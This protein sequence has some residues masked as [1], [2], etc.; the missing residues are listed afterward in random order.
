MGLD[1][2]TG[3]WDTLDMGNYRNRWNH[4]TAFSAAHNAV[5]AASTAA[6][7]GFPP[8]DLVARRVAQCPHSTPFKG[9]DALSTAVV[10][11]VPFGKRG[12]IEVRQ[13]VKHIGGRWDGR[14]KQ[15]TLSRAKC[16]P[17]AI[18]IINELRLYTGKTIAAPKAAFVSRIAIPALSRII[19]SVPYEDRQEVKTLGA[20]WSVTNR[21]WYLSVPQNPDQK[22]SETVASLE[23]KGWVDVD[24]TENHIISVILAQMGSSAP[25]K[26][27]GDIQYARPADE[28][29]ARTTVFAAPQPKSKSSWRSSSTKTAFSVLPDEKQFIEEVLQ[30]E[31]AQGTLNAIVATRY[32]LRLTHPNGTHTV[33]HILTLNGGVGVRISF[34]KGVNSA[35]HSYMPKADGRRC[36]DTLVWQ[37]YQMVER[38]D[39]TAL[40]LVEHCGTNITELGHTHS[41]LEHH[42]NIVVDARHVLH[43]RYDGKIQALP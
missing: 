28:A 11:D 1:N 23:V 3:F 41:E 15:W 12:S 40:Q 35:D 32:A 25:Y 22:F 5:A 14:T 43:E 10:L 37:G 26:S 38:L 30:T 33:Y 31:V 6:L 4:S 13:W 9:L 8:A 42:A 19:L 20:A 7:S 39:L 29:A 36:W 21:Y 2:R 24:S 17:D 16:T 18:K 34:V 27:V